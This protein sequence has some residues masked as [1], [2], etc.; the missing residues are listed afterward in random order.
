M[1]ISCL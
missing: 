1:R